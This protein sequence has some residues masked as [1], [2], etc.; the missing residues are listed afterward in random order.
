MLFIFNGEWNMFFQFAEDCPAG[1]VV[2]AVSC[3]RF[4]VQQYLLANCPA[5][6]GTFL[7]SPKKTDQPEGER[8]GGWDGR[9]VVVVQE[10]ESGVAPKPG[11]LSNRSTLRQPGGAARYTALAAQEI[12][13]AFCVA[14]I[15]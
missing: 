9:A 6:T 2:A 7:C 10:K 4:V 8:T 11:T 1:Q 15:R 14:A 5:T 12:G 3:H 13:P